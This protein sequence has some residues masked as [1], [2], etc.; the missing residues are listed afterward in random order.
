MEKRN[1]KQI[2]IKLPR[3]SVSHLQKWPSSGPATTDDIFPFVLN[4]AQQ[5]RFLP[6]QEGSAEVDCAPSSSH[7]GAAKCGCG[8]LKRCGFH[9]WTLCRSS[10]FQPGGTRIPWESCGERSGIVE[11][12]RDWEMDGSDHLRSWQRS[13]ERWL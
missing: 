9:T 1:G 10:Q 5:G 4:S 12:D 2:T 11:R 13:K 8:G 6:K 3:V 7:T